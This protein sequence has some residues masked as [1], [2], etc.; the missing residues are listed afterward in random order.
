M[1]TLFT[2][3]DSNATSLFHFCVTSLLFWSQCR[4]RISEANLYRP[5]CCAASLEVKLELWLCYYAGDVYRC[6]YPDCSYSTPKRSQLACHTRAVHLQVRS[7]TCPECG[8]AFVERSHL[9]RH[10]RTHLT[11]KPFA[12]SQC[13]YTSSRRDKLK[14]H[15]TKHHPD[16]DSNGVQ[17]NAS[18]KSRRRANKLLKSS[19]GGQTKSCEVEEAAVVTE[20]AVV[21]LVVSVPVVVSTGRDL[22][23]DDT[24]GPVV[25]GSVVVPTVNGMEMC[26]LD[27]V[28]VPSLN[29][30]TYKLLVGPASDCSG[31]A[32]ILPNG[33]DAVDLTSCG[34]ET[35][36]AS[37]L[38][39]PSSCSSLLLLGEVADG[40]LPV[41][42]VV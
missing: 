23:T 22:V 41:T 25:D 20:A 2:V 19:A 16:T 17:D 27:G 39:D 6:S 11:E 21:N 18:H 9:V 31:G 10:Q 13:S 26:F 33:T 32:V 37:G 14:E 42:T 29:A 7:H 40:Q 38:P 15:C 8:R 1:L 28:G 30:G 36:A 24:N 34:V 12:C 35:E 4:F 3:R 5:F